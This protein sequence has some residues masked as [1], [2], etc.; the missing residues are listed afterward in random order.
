MNEIGSWR[1]VELLSKSWESVSERER[2][3]KME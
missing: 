1:G 2:E 3:G